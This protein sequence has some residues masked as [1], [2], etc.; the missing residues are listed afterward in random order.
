MVLTT[1]TADSSMAFDPVQSIVDAQ[2]VVF[3]VLV[4]LGSMSVI[5]WLITF[6][7]WLWMLQVR[8]ASKRFMDQYLNADHPSDLLE[9]AEADTSSSESRVCIAGLEELA[10]IRERSNDMESLARD[11]INVERSVQRTQ[12]IEMTR[13]ERWVSIL[14]T[15]GS[16][17]PF[18]GLF[19]TIWGIMYAIVG[20]G[21]GDGG[22]GRLQSVMPDIGEALI[23]TAIGLAA[24][25][26]AVMAYNYFVGCIRRVSLELDGFSS[27][28]LNLLRRFFLMR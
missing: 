25:I 18:I 9:L 15:T 12:V 20:L 27:D 11:F 2:G 13:F 22:A 21:S 24:A 23:A 6:Y 26:P 10:R 1:S 7:K 14:G 19:G 28:F 16:T 5:C 8:R 3:L 4:L 17:A